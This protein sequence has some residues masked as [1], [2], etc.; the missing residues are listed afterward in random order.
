MDYLLKNKIAF[1]TGCDQGI[2]YSIC[3]AFVK[4][5]AI[6]YAN[7]LKMESISKLSALNDD[8]SGGKAIPVQ[9]DIV[10]KHEIANCINKIKNEQNGRLD[11]LINNAGVKIDCLIEMIDDESIKKMMDVNVI[12]LIHVTQMALSL[13]KRNPGGAS[14]IN[15]SSIVGLKGNTGQSVY[16]ATKGAVASLTKSW[17]K[18]FAPKKIRVNAVAPGSIDTEMF[19]TTSDETMK[20][21][22]EAI[23]MGRLGKPEEVASVILFLASDLS[24]YVTGE[25]IGVNGGLF[26]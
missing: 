6:V 2:G 16:G 21:S 17:A 8:L 1:V 12:G 25:L 15:I 26:M 24:S 3:E 13:L 23:G 20:K 7:V 10:D 9:F 14:I 5:G 19:Y 11:I 18:E 22:I 4:A